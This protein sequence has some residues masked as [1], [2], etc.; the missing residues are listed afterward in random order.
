[1]KDRKMVRMAYRLILG[2]E[3]ESDEVL[4]RVFVDINELR[5]Q[6]LNSDEFLSCFSK[7]PL[8]TVSLI[9]NGQLQI[10]NVNNT[11]LPQFFWI[12]YSNA[13]DPISQSA[14]NS[15]ISIEHDLFELFNESGTFLDLGGNIGAF[16]LSFGAMGWKGYVFEASLENAHILKKSIY[17]NDFDITVINKAVYENT[18]NIYFGQHGPFGLI[19]NEVTSGIRWEEI[20]C[21]C[22]D[23]WYT[24][25][26]APIKIDFIKMDIEGSEVAAL[27][28]MKKMLEKYGFPPIFVE[29]NSWTLFLQNE[30]QKSLLE[31]AN[32]MG[33]I[34]Y[35]LKKDRLLKYDINNFPTILCTDFILLKEIPKHFKINIFEEYVQYPNEVITFIIQNLSIDSPKHIL[36]TYCFVLKEFP[37]YASN[38]QI[39]RRLEHIIEKNIQD[40]F[41]EKYLGWF[42]K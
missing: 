12:V 11:P 33:Y 37:N 2:R 42:I 34:P 24:Q 3:P 14:R 19:Q 35:I 21:M 9:D 26:E 18:G 6:F 16:S 36:M 5:E 25:E 1:M 8:S 31:T 32:K 30:T 15:K 38:I 27:R 39:K 22:L 13:N 4:D 28:G 40:K 29:S 23:D 17:I 10:I 41:L 7:V 20:P